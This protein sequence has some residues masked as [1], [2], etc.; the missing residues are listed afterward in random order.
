MGSIS[1][2]F[3]YKNFTLSFLIDHRQGGTMLSETNARLYGDG[4][5]KGT[6]QGREGGLIF[7]QNFFTQYTAV[8]ENGSKNDIQINAEK[9]WKAMGGRIE[10]T[11]EIFAASA[12]NTRLRELIIGYSVPVKKLNGLRISQLHFS[13]VGRNLFFIYR[14]SKTIDPDLRVGTG[15]GTTGISEFALPTMRSIGANLKVDFK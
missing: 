12:T 4:Q 7:G 1:N 14:A 3:S 6:L 8:L 2:T 9:F 13:L 10:S 5:A 11:D 15:P